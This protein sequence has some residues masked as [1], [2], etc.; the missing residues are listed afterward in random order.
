ME[1]EGEVDELGNELATCKLDEGGRGTG[2]KS[3]SLS[4][5]LIWGAILSLGFLSEL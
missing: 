1:E 5:A 4:T 2:M 3:L